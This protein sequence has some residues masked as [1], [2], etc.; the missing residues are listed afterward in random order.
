MVSL[1][2]DQAVALVEEAVG[3]QIVSCSPE[4]F[5]ESASPTAEKYLL[6]EDFEEWNQKS[7]ACN[8]AE[9]S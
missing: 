2:V 9:W 8:L 6:R 3:N 5:E 4:A 1:G 7:E